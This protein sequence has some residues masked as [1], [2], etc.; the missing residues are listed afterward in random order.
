MHFSWFDIALLVSAFGFVWG[1]FWTGLI[2]SIGGVVGLF[3]GSI[4]ASRY[5]EQFSDLIS[6]VFAGNAIASKVF[7]FVLLFLL[8][9]RLV[10]VAFYFINK[11]FNIFAIVP[12]LK[13]VNKLGGAI[14]GFI[15]ASLF[16]GITLQFIVRLPIS[17]GFASTI[18]D[19]A[20]A[21]YFLQLSGW[22]VPLFPKVLKQ[23]QDASKAINDKLPSN[24]NVNGAVNAANAIKNSGFVQ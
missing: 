11:V 12:G 20:V 15:E 10:G 19:S 7:A 21:A 1:G 3:L 23:A 2:Q 22:L 4:I 9:T 16:I 17:G 13:L 8:V 24:I 5:Y 18:H 14:F 6:P